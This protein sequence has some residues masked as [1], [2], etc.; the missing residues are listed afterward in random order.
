MSRI[1]FRKGE[2]R[3]FLQEAMKRINCP[4]L[5]ELINRGIDVNYSTLK[6][7]YAEERLIP[8]ALFNELIGL[9]ELNKRDFEFELI[10]DNWGQVKGGK[11]SKK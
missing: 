5:R 4:S 10:N 6:N 2:Q 9:S 11:I 1:K 7:Y 8:E 3:K